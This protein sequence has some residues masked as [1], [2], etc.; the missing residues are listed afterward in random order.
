MP[1]ARTGS[2]PGVTRDAAGTSASASYVY[3]VGSTDD[4]TV[5]V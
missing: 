1:P 5:T 2:V 3:V 4:F